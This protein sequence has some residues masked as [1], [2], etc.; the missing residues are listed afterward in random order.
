MVSAFRSDGN[1]LPCWARVSVLDSFLL[2]LIRTFSKNHAKR[3]LKWNYLKDYL[4]AR[5]KR[6]SEADR[7]PNIEELIESK[8]VN[9][10]IISLDNYVSALCDYGENPDK[11]NQSQKTFFLNQNLER[12]INNGGFNQFYFNSSGDFA[13]E[14]IDSLKAIEAHKTAEIVT[15]ANDQFPEGTVPKDRSERQDILEQIEKD[16][17]VVW[18]KLGQ[19]FYEYVDDL[20]QL[21]LEYIRKN[22]ADFS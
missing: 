10:S 8:D 19:K 14:T 9:E 7:K 6:M 5:I 4:E 17:N 16:A 20:N 18:G 11:L 1:V 2:R 21:N 3:L 13:H 15:K 12:E 22:K